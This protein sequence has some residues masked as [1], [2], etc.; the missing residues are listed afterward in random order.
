M[1]EV[2]SEPGVMAHIITARRQSRRISSSGP[3]CNTEQV[4]GYTGICKTPSP[5]ANKIEEKERKS[6]RER[7]GKGRRDSN[8]SYKRQKKK[9]RITTILEESKA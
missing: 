8:S 1:S 7:R 9:R 4:C 6:E 2:V 5:S 3:A